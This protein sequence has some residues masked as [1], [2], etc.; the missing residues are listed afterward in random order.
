MGVTESKIERALCKAVEAFCGVAYKFVSPGRRGVPDRLV[1]FP[2]APEH[3][4]IVS[5]Y[6][7]FVETKAPGKKP[8]PEQE[9]EI[10]RL[11]DMGFDVAVVDGK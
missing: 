3:R 2:V 9:R 8:R 1:L 4:E 6:V 11:R 7:Y 5:A 10:G